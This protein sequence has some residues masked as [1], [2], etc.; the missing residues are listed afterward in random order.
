[1]SAAPLSYEQPIK[2]HYTDIF[3]RCLQRTCE[4]PPAGWQRAVLELPP[5]APRVEMRE[6][7]RFMEELLRLIRERC[8]TADPKKTSPQGFWIEAFGVSEI[9]DRYLR[10]ARLKVY[11]GESVPQKVWID[12]APAAGSFAAGDIFRA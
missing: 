5:D 9:V 4:P 2:E 3:Y 1:M 11:P 8:S 10:G 7:D 6:Q 12:V